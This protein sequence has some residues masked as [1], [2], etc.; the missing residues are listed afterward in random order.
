MDITK[1][2]RLCNEEKLITVFPV[3]QRRC[4]SCI[5]KLNTNKNR[6]YMKE[7]YKNNRDKILSNQK[8][9]IETRYKPKREETYKKLGIEPNQKGRRRT[10]FLDSELEAKALA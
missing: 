6:E 5:Y 3:A 9:L 10:I 7:Y 4:S 2:C 8:L 1:I